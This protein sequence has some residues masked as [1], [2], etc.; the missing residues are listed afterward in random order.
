MKKKY[1]ATP[2]DKKDWIAFTKRLENVYDKNVDF[3][4]QNT[5]VNKIRKLDLHGLSLNQANQIVKKF[6][7]ESFENGYKKLL[8]ITGKGLRSKVH[9]N[10]YLSEQMSVLKHSVPEFI[11]NDEDLFGK[12]S[13]ISTADLKDGGD[14]AI[15]IFLKSIK[16]F[17][18]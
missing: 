9:R 7:I 2:K 3:I 8:I 15:C 5:T 10:P 11:K 12:I 6:I 13:R 16:R 18:E 14:G 17:K 1:P 4:K